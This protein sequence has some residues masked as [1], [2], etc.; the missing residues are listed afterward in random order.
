M[1]NWIEQ[2]LRDSKQKKTGA[3]LREGGDT[4]PALKKQS[5]YEP[6]AICPENGL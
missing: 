5:V 3:H 4:Y 2:I 1:E 6:Q